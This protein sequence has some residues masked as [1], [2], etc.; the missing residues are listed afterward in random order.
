[1]GWKSEKTDIVYVIFRACPA[2]EQTLHNLANSKDKINKKL[3]REGKTTTLKF[4]G[5]GH[6][7]FHIL[8]ILAAL[9]K[10]TYS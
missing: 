7:I 2:I 10:K 3:I 9:I 8:H 6:S 4:L 1:M 5:I